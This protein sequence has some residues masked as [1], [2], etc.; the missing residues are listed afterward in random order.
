MAKE[1]KT[2]DSGKRKEFDS[3]M[4]RD[5]NI[6]KPRFEL[7]LPKEIPYEDQLLTRWAKLM[8]RGAEKYAERNWEQASGESEYNRFKESAFRHFTRYPF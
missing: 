2:K 5:T 3:G 1:Y 4:K 7:I 6:G 8:G